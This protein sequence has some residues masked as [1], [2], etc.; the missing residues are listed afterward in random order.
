MT[1]E[2]ATKTD[3]LRSRSRYGRNARSRVSAR[4]DSR[5]GVP[6]YWEGRQPRRRVKLRL[7]TTSARKA[8]LDLAAHHGI[9]TS[10]QDMSR[11][12]QQASPDTL[13]AVLKCLGVAAAN[14]SEIRAAL[15]QAEEQKW[16]ELLPPV[17]TAWDGKPTEVVVRLPQTFAAVSPHAKIHFED[18]SCNSLHWE[19]L[20]MRVREA[21]E[22]EGR[23]Y[24]ARSLI[25]PALPLGYHHLEVELKDRKHQSLIISAPS[26][27]YS[28]PERFKSWGVF[29]PTYA[30]HNEASWGAGNVGDLRRLVNWAGELGAGVVATLPMLAAFLDAPICDPSPYSPASRLFWNDFYID[31]EAVPEFAACPVAQQLFKSPT[32][33]QSLRSF[34][35]T[36][37]IDY[38]PEMRARRNV[39]EEMAKFFFAQSS[40]RRKNFESYVRAHPRLMDY[41]AFRAACDRTR[42]SWH[43]WEERMRNGKLQPGDFVP[44]VRDYHL[45]V[46]WLA[47]EQMNQLTNHCRDRSIRLYL[48]LPLGVNSDGYDVWRER[49]SFALAAGA[50]AP[51][52]PVFTAGQDWGFAPLH[53]RRMRERGYSYVL[54]YLRFQMRHAGLLRIDHILGLHRL[55]WIPHGFPPEK[56][57]YVSYP[58]SEL[59]AILSLES[60]RHKTIIAGEN[61]GTVPPE[62]NEDMRRH[63]FRETFVVQYEQQTNPKKPL[64]TPPSF[65]VASLNT[66]DMPPFV[67]QCRGLDIQD[68]A[69]LGLVQTEKVQAEQQR[70]QELCDALRSYLSSRGLLPKEDPGEIALLRACLEWLAS[71]PAEIVLVNLED[72][73]GETGCQNVPGT[74]AERPNWRRKFKLALEN[75][76]SSPDFREFLASIDHRRR[77]SRVQAGD[78]SK[79]ARAERPRLKTPVRTTR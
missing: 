9:Q 32:F 16:R 65:S 31:I 24:V 36:P 38:R 5:R 71:S 58:A 27:S 75:I 8:L 68:R 20:S 66:H 50:G 62:V 47:H 45:Y 51:P 1:A 23:T 78:P 12:R 46:Q 64:R 73:W 54:E 76:L 6:D 35:E 25:L 59:Q 33:Q 77:R 13:K 14:A 30:L 3:Y 53:P 49:D 4:P 74:S 34:R 42:S 26:K 18:G 69:S 2:R 43:V 70:R 72:L 63:A 39:L 15:L 11:K 55:F 28:P 40:S 56:G 10:Y 52:D 60:H 79:K 41:A 29:A 57:A 7:Q 44:S 67:A 17:I 48:D 19:P 61:L 21:A 22:I 37:F